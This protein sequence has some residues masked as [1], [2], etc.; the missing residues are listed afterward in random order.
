MEYYEGGKRQNKSGSRL[1]T[2][3]VISKN[4]VTSE[5]GIAN[6]FSKFFRTFES[7][8]NKVDTTTAD[9]ITINEVKEVFFFLKNKQ[10]SR[11]RQDKP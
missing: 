4:N 6:E 7:F 2:K 10:K 3:L 9:S 8:L 1:P 11:L 5:T